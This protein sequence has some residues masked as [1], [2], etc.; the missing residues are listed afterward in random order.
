MSA[1]MT[2]SDSMCVSLGGQYLTLSTVEQDMQYPRLCRRNLE[3]GRISRRCKEAVGVKIRQAVVLLSA[4]VVFVTLP[5]LAWSQSGL[6]SGYSSGETGN[7]TVERLSLTYVRPPPRTTVHN[8]VFDAFGPNPL[9]TTALIAGLD[10]E[11]NTPPE[12]RTRR[13]WLRRTIRVKFWDFFG[14]NVN[15]LWAR[16]GL[17]GGH[18]VLP[19]RL[20]GTH[21]AAALCSDVDFDGAPWK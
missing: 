21:S 9:L 16:S 2:L 1:R 8:Y 14:W 18:L 19:M 11:T 4:S 17:Q 20:Q 5:F 12:W 13:C 3:G 15:A 10:Q 6:G 7:A